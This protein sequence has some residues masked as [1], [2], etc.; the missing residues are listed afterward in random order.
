MSA[1]VEAREVAYSYPGVPDASGPAKAMAV[2]GVSLAVEAASMTAVIG[3]NGS[4]KSTLIRML[5]GL[6]R[7][8]S[9]EILLHGKPLDRWQPRLR[10]REIAYM[11]QATATVFPF[12]VI[13]IVLSGI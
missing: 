6:L 11:P 13:D 9:G 2:R 3:A 7:P 1:L 10:A 8:V 5:A 4:G 12:P